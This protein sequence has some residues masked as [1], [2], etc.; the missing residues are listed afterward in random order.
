MKIW[1]DDV[2]YP[3][4]YYPWMT[5]YLPRWVSRWLTPW[6]WVKTSNEAYDLIL[7]C[8]YIDEPI[9]MISF[10]HDLGGEDTSVAIADYIEEL[11]FEGKIDRIHWFIHSANPVGRKRLH[12]ALESA[13]RYWDS[14]D[15][16]P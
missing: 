4:T 13:D 6:T 1:I 15:E 8:L 5:K 12:Q 10:D 11:A 3:P 9:E 14:I 16:R 2:R 7:Y